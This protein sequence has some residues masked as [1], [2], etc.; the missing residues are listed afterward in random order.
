MTAAR[1]DAYPSKTITIVVGFAPGELIDVI[2][3]SLDRSCKAS[4]VRLLLLKIVPAPPAIS[5][6]AASPQRSLMGIQFLAQQRRCQL[7]KR[8]TRSAVIRRTISKPYRL[9]RLLR[10]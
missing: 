1:A 9:P 6:I 2:A 7:M 4:S 3:G 10:R 8:F 5:R